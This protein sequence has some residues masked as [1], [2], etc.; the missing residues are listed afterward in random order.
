MIRVT[1]LQTG[2]ANLKR[3][4]ERGQEGRSALGRKLDILRDKTWAGPLVILAWLIEHPEGRFVVDTGDAAANSMPGYMPRWNYF[5]THQVQIKVAPH[6]EIGPRLQALQIDPARDIDRVILTHLHHDHTGGLHHFPHNRIICERQ[7]WKIARSLRGKVMGC[8]PQRWPTWF[9]PE[10]IDLNGPPVGPFSSSYPITKDG[11]IF[12]VPTPG[13]FYGHVSVVVWA[14]EITYFLLG[15]ATYTQ[16]DLCAGIVDGVTYD[17]AVSLA[18]IQAI[19]QF[20][21][22]EPTVLLPAHDPDG[23]R[24]LAEGEIYQS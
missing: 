14:E 4:Q 1:A 3:A 15:D 6:E 20:A 13:H 17:P 10:L 8:L 24:R 16:A 12:L 18:S 23:P 5:F 11:R 21:A 2:T 9:K 7:G 19:Q 22:Q